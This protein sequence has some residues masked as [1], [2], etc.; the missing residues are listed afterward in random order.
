MRERERERERERDLCIAMAI[1]VAYVRVLFLCFSTMSSTSSISMTMM[2][3]AIR[4]AV[5]DLPMRQPRLRVWCGGCICRRTSTV[6]TAGDVV[7]EQQDLKQDLCGNESK[8]VIRHGDKRGGG[9]DW[10]KQVSDANQLDMDSINEARMHILAKEAFIIDMDGVIYHGNRLL[11]GVAEFVAWLHSSRKRFLFLTNS[12]DKTPDELQ[13]KLARLG[14]VVDAS[15]FYTSAQATAAFL[16]SQRPSGSVYV[17]GDPGLHQALYSA[18]Y[19][20]ND[21]NP[22]Y[23]VVGETPSYSYE[24]I[25]HAVHLVLNGAKL[26]GTNCDKTDP[27]PDYPGEVIPAAGSLIT[28]IEKAAGVNAYFVGKVCVNICFLQTMA[29]RDDN[30]C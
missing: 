8:K 10:R 21:V 12:S 17:I 20:M 1:A 22:D 26:I 14:V 30:A 15:H 13:R 18:G 27:S 24:K 5:R 9:W 28:P 19:V 16:A 25:E 6:A 4:Q 29:K 3:M 23:V 11:P 2:M 7:A